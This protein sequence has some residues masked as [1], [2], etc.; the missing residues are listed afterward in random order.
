[1]R[2]PDPALVVLV[3]ASGSGKSTWAAAHF[4]DQEVVSSDALRGVVGSGPHDLDA[5]ADAFGVLETVVAARLK[6]GLTTVVDTLGLDAAKRQAWLAAARAAGLPAVVVLLDTPDA[7]CRRRN[8]A[9]DRPVPA[10]VLA[11][12]LRSVRDVRPL[13]EAEG[14]DLVEPVAAEGGVV[15]PTT[16]H[17]TE[18]APDR[19]SSLGL[20]TVLQVS[21]FPWGEDPLAWLTGIA[22]AADEA[23]FAGLAL[24]DHLIQ[25]PQVGR[26]WEPIPEPWVTL[27]AVAALGTDLELGTLCTPVTFRPAGV[28]AKAAAT[29]S[30]LTGG[31]AFVGI[32]AGWWEREHAAYGIP[33]PAARDRLDHLEHAIVTMKALWAAGTKAYDAHGVVLP[34]TTSYP[35]PA[36]RIP[37]VVGGSG[38]RRT[39]RIAAQHGD[40]CNL[41][42]TDEDE[43]R[44]LVGV[45]HAHCDDVG[46]DRDEV[47]VTVLDLPVVGRDRDDVWARVERHRGRTPAA[48]YAARTHAAT[49]AGHRDRWA[50]LA[51]L[52][53]RTVFLATPDLDRP[54]D[55]LD[56]AGLT[57]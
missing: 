18:P 11:R 13:L 48:S 20:R 4:R 27:G 40:A 21:R 1:M 5:S 8:A 41:R 46:R 56:L 2:L 10:P 55:V 50:R 47:E 22:R 42:T 30:A 35:R 44:R 51:G 29:L 43:L 16:D 25:V 38:E 54:E 28:T 12:Q 32:G 7:E 34:E 31:R 9:R 36:G 3:G 15:E 14:W 53:V 49:V 6:R 24:M 23:G 57:A 17:P 37:V 33:F 45:L 19:I 39:L 26:A 52:G